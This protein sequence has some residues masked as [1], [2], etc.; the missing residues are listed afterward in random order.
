[1]ETRYFS[2]RLQEKL[3]NE[4]WIVEKD[5]FIKR[6][7]IRCSLES[8]YLI[9]EN[10]H[11][12]TSDYFAYLTHLFINKD[13]EVEALGGKFYNEYTDYRNLYLD[14][15]VNKPQIIKECIE[16]VLELQNIGVNF[17]DIH[18]NNIIVNKESH[19][20]LVDLDETKLVILCDDDK[21][22]LFIN[23]ILQSMLFF[24][25]KSSI[26]PWIRPKDVL[27]E[28]ENKKVLSSSFLDSILEKD[29]FASFYSNVDNYLE[30][31]CDKEKSFTL[32]K[33]LRNKYPKW[34][35]K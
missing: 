20:K 13:D 32:R 9:D 15:N 27:L 34:F 30:E 31:L 24:E 25:V 35:I 4:N 22:P 26:W 7:K 19:M 21:T 29:N 33:E 12:L 6:K 18:A 8:L 14:S 10:K 11:K 16:A 17:T 3:I 23:L 1:M 5:M 28:L 2:L